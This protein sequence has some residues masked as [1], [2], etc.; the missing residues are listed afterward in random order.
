MICKNLF[1]CGR[2]AVRLISVLIIAGDSLT[3]GVKQMEEDEK[4]PSASS[5]LVLHSFLPP[6]LRTSRFLRPL[7]E[8]SVFLPGFLI[9][10][11]YRLD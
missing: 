2:T 5:D 9:D 10:P 11:F 8:I 4:D 7:L 6:F 3:H 1:C